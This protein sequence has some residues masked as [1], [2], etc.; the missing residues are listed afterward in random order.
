MKKLALVG[1]LLAGTAVF[2]SACGGGG[3]A[4]AHLPHSGRAAASGSRN[5][6]AAHLA[7]LQEGIEHS[8]CMRSHG[9]PSYPDPDANG[10]VKMSS[11][12]GVNPLS[13]QF[14]SAEK[15][16][17][18]F[19]EGG[20]SQNSTVW[21]QALQEKAL[22]FGACMRSHGIAGYPDPK[23]LKYGFMLSIPRS[24]GINVNSPQFAKATQICQ[25]LLNVNPSAGQP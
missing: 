4:V 24:S 2:T 12:S 16:C 17:D 5:G 20:V 23:P 13:A 6:G 10:N 9:V 14:Q 15:A 11:D 19:E 25:P 1:V 8:E 21:G 22:K 3:P 7:S 18:R